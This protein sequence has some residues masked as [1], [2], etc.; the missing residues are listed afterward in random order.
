MPQTCDQRHAT[1]SD[2]ATGALVG[3]IG[4]LL[5]G[6]LMNRSHSLFSSGKQALLGGDEPSIFQS[7]GPRREAFQHEPATAQAAQD[8][9]ISVLDR[10]LDPKEKQ[11]GG[12][13]LHYIFSVVCGAIYGGLL[14]AFPSISRSRGLAAGAALWVI[15]DEVAMPA[16][17]YVK[18]PQKYP[19]HKHVQALINHLVF[20]FVTDTLHRMSCRAMGKRL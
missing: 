17:G 15:A 7:A 9:A 11:V 5:A 6:F 14:S 1:A 16:L 19:F 2:V 8:L 20:G 13:L 10:P 18:P 4:G 3:A 12:L